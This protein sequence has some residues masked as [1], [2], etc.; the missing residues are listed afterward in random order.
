MQGGA[1]RAA[2]RLHWGLQAEDVSSTM[3][4]HHKQSKDETVQTYQ[5]SRA[6]WTRLR[7]R[8]R[9]EQIQRSFAQHADTRPAGLEPFSDDRSPFAGRLLDQC[10]PTDVWHLHWISGFVDLRT[11]FS[12]ATKPVVWTLHDMNPFTGGCHYD[13]G[14]GRFEEKCGA[15]PQLGA[16]SEEDLSRSIWERK[17]KAFS[18][19]RSEQLHVV[20]TSQWMAKQAL[21][22]SLFQ[23]FDVSIIPLGLDTDVFAPREGIG[24]RQ[25]LQIPAEA[26][27]ILFAAHSAENTRKG[28]TYL[29]DALQALQ[30]EHA[31]LYCLSVGRGEPE[32]HGSIDHLHLGTIQSD[33]LLSAIYSC[34]DVF[35]M[36]STQEAF[37]QTALESMACGTPVVGFDAGG[38][39]DIVRPEETGWLAE[40]GNARD[41]RAALG[42]ALTDGVARVRLADRC[43]EMVTEEYTL[44]LQ[45]QR[46]AKLYESMLK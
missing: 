20:A 16:T 34:A 4:V 45:A 11:F 32:L 28:F 15:C 46:Y 14:C 29:A 6:L 13:R 5:P 26:E 30:N 2:Y 7:R 44:A 19:I 18:A 8:W 27:V 41:F 9:R 23:P 21:R 35:V 40:K 38:I 37:G 39:P 31:N 3:F 24:F 22:S 12:K 25:S 33:R 36:P 42:Q 1:A 10:P 17:K 43:R